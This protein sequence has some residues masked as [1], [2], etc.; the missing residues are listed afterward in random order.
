MRVGLRRRLSRD[1][2]VV[3]GLGRD[4]DGGLLVV[5]RPRGVEVGGAD[6]RP[7]PARYITQLSLQLFLRI[8]NI[9]EKS[10]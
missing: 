1:I 7:P 4:R 5:S 6:S 10:V 8:C 3:R 2:A 9:F